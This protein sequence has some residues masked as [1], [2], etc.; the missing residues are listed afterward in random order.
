MSTTVK[1]LQLKRLNEWHENLTFNQKQE[2]LKHWKEA[3]A[4]AP[5]GDY[6]MIIEFMD[7]YLLEKFLNGE[8]D[9]IKN[10]EKNK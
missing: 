8:L 7:N 1:E 3:F 4:K 9:Y 6:S 2:F 5:N 10:I